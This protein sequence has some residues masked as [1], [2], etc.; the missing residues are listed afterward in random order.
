MLDYAA[1]GAPN[2]YYGRIKLDGRII[3]FCRHSHTTERDAEKCAQ[4]RLAA[5]PVPAPP[6]PRPLRLTPEPG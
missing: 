6:V 1:E 4:L 2:G 3:W 5:G